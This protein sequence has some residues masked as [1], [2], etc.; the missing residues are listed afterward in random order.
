VL[1][2]LLPDCPPEDANAQLFEIAGTIQ[3]TN[4]LANQALASLSFAAPSS[5]F[6]RTM[7]E[8]IL[9]SPQLQKLRIQDAEREKALGAAAMADQEF[10]TATDNAYGWV[11]DDEELT[12]DGDIRRRKGKALVTNGMREHLRRQLGAQWFNFERISEAY[13]L[14]RGAKR[15]GPEGGST[16]KSV[17]AGP[18]SK[19]ESNVKDQTTRKRTKAGTS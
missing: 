17:S 6:L 2:L 1:L 3:Q 10:K 14:Q 7:D 8:M 13:E 15:S 4:E 9:A 5:R 16:L 19:A 18:T 11:D 12:P